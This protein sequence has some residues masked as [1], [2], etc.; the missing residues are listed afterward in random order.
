MRREGRYQWRNGR[1]FQW[2]TTWVRGHRGE[3]RDLDQMIQRVESDIEYI[4]N[5]SLW[6]DLVIL[7]RTTMAFSGKNAY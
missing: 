4:N 1:W 5:W 2:G 7:I 3:T 6:L